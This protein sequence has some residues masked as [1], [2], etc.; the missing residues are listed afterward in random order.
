MYRDHVS[1]VSRLIKMNY[2]QWLYVILDQILLLYRNAPSVND[3]ASEELPSAAVALDPSPDFRNS[4]LI[5]FVEDDGFFDLAVFEWALQYCKDNPVL[6]DRKIR[7]FE[8]VVRS[9]RDYRKHLEELNKVL[10]SCP[11]E[12]FDSLMDTVMQDPVILPSNNRCDRTTVLRQL[13]VN[14]IDPF[15][16]EPLT[17]D[18]VKPDRELKERI[19]AYM[20]EKMSALQH[21]S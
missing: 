13:S 18:M 14:P 1:E 8:L 9:L 16:R 19:H 12:F 2:N 4:I 17:M 5:S 3:L 7:S 20:K 6:D 21:S 11:D 15:T 10:D